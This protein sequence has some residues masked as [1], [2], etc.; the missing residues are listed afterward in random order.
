MVWQEL[1]GAGHIASAVRKQREVN[2][3]PWLSFSFFGDLVS[4]CI[5]R[6][7]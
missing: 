3:G 7:L 5:P 4:L 1:K 2:V 6:C